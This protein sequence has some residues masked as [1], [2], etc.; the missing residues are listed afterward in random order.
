M[1][2][3]P[4]D[5][6][7]T[8]VL[9]SIVKSRARSAAEAQAREALAAGLRDVGVLD[10]DDYSSLRGGY[11]VVFTGVHDAKREA[12]ARLPAAQSAGYRLAYVREVRA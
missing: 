1:S 5:H 2:W 8:I 10:S 7:Y 11:W 9:A 4:G 12:A 3:P 6:G